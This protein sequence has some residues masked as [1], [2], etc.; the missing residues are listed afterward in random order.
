[1]R[2]L[3]GVLLTVLLDQ[4]TKLWIQTEFLYGEQ[5][6]VIAGLF[7]LHYIRNSGAAWGVLA[8]W[9]LLLILFAVVMLVVLVRRRQELFYGLWLGRPA[10]ALLL[11]GIVG[12]LMDRI[13]FGY[14]VDFLDFHWQGH[15]FPAFNV[16]DSAICIGVGLYLVGSL[17]GQRGNR[18]R[19]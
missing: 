13:R 8:G 16:A 3:P 15:H 18:Q 1:M 9:R 19:C 12:N 6:Q 14:V 11:G 2:L 7:N 4:L 10:L 5:R 17:I